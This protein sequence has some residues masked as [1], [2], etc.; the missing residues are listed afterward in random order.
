MCKDAFP[1]ALPFPQSFIYLYNENMQ[2]ISSCDVNILIVDKKHI[3]DALLQRHYQVGIGQGRAKMSKVMRITT[4]GLHNNHFIPYAS[5]NVSYEK[6]IQVEKSVKVWELG[7]TIP[8][9]CAEK[10]ETLTEFRTRYHQINV[11]SLQC[12]PGWLND[13]ECET[14]KRS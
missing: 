14:R 3:L 2:W 7:C 8:W 10:T 6:A 13:G 4:N 11:T 5:Q 9:K 1:K 12:C